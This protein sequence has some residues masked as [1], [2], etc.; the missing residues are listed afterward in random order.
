M[1]RKNTPSIV[2]LLP[3]LAARAAGPNR[4][5]PQQQSRAMFWP[6]E[7][8]AKTRLS[9]CYFFFR[10]SKEKVKTTWAAQHGKLY[11]PSIPIAANRVAR[12]W[13][14]LDI[15]YL[16]YYKQVAPTGHIVFRKYNLQ[17]GHRAIKPLS[18]YYPRS[19]S[20]LSPMFRLWLR[21]RT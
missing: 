20:V 7:P 10:R 5:P 2:V 6:A 13:A 14:K 4:V 1:A 21:P 8:L 11:M 12:Y 9:F 18:N 16:F 17:L 19:I 15:G 3:H